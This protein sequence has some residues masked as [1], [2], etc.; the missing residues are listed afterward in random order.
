MWAFK[1]RAVRRQLRPDRIG[2]ADAALP[3][4]VDRS[5][6]DGKVQATVRT[7]RVQRAGGIR[8]NEQHKLHEGCEA[9]DA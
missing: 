2:P 5:G 6:G 1:T 7:V 8:A 3:D 4:R 9:R